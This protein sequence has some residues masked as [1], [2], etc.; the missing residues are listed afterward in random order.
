MN[1]KENQSGARELADYAFNLGQV[2]KE[3]KVI[4]LSDRNREGLMALVPH[5]MTL[6][7]LK[8]FL[9]ELPER[10]DGTVAL[11]DAGSFCGYVNEHKRPETRIFA[12]I[13]KV[14]YLFSAV[15]NHHVPGAD[16]AA[17]W[18]DHKATLE[19]RLSEQFNVWRGI[20]GKMLGQVGFAEFLKDNRMDIF[21][22][23]NASILELVMELEATV[24]S[25][26]TGKVPTNS[27]MALGFTE[28]VNTTGAGGKK[29]DVPDRITLKMPVFEGMDAVEIVVDFKFR[30]HD[31]NLAFGIKMIGADRMIREAVKAAQLRIMQETE[32]PVYV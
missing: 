22:P 8:D 4:N 30:V 23:D 14:P 21:E 12:Q 3:I 31:G 25:R 16:G 7:D 11:Y 29:V 28:N 6:T 13:L 1:E 10:K 24:D 19:L 18:G 2:S 17:G 20:D 9:P 15:F 32:L 5:G 27:G 26:C